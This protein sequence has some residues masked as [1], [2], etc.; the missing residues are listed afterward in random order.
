MASRPEFVIELCKELSV[1][2]PEKLENEVQKIY[3]KE[4]D[5]RIFVI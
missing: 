2:K 3:S 5:Y 1:L 4:I